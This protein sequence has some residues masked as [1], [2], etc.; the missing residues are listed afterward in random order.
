MLE[1]GKNRQVKSMTAWLILFVQK[2][3]GRVLRLCINYHQINKI[4]IV[5]CYLGLI[6]TDLQDH[7]SVCTISKKIDYKNSYPLILFTVPDE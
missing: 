7:V 1:S 5:N 3:H 2:A 6:M 4:T